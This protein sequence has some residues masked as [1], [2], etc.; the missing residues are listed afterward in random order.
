[1]IYVIGCGGTGSLLARDIPKLLIGSDDGLVLI[2]GDAVEKKNLLRQSYQSQDIGENKAIALSRKINSLYGMVSTGLDIYLSKD[3]LLTLI[4]N[5]ETKMPVIIGCVDNDATRKIIET[6][7]KKLKNAVY[8][9]SAN[10]AY[11]GN[12]YVAERLDGKTYGVLRSNV[13]RLKNDKKPTD[14][15]C[16][17]QAAKGN[18]QYL[19]TNARMAVAVL[20]HL[21]N[22]LDRTE[23][24]LVGVTKLERFAEIHV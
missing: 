12:V 16:Q 14:I 6:T 13:Y 10:S 11:T 4:R 5:N 15:S 2:D 7:F 24:N 3:E 8:I 18:I 20:E 21:S 19:V 23:K 22:I 1:M 9:D 17:E